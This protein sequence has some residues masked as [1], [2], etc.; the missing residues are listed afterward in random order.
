MQP[1]WCTTDWIT[2]AKIADE[3]CN[4]RMVFEELTPISRC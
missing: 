1:I 2:S 4:L 3:Q